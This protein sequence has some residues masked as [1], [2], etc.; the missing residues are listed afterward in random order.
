MHAAQLHV[1]QLVH[2]QLAARV[3]QADDDAVDLVRARTMARDVVDGAD[4]RARR[5]RAARMPS[6]S[7]KPTI[8][9]PS[10]WRRCF[11]SAAR[12]SAAGPVPTTSS[13]SRG[14][15]APDRP[16]EGEAP[17]GDERDD[18]RRGKQ[19]HA[20]A[21]HQRRKP[22]VEQRQDQRGRAE[23]LQ[24]AHEQLAAVG[25]DAQVVQLRVVQAHLADGG[26][27]D[28]LDGATRSR[29]HRSARPARGAAAR[30]QR[31]ARPSSSTLSNRIRT[32]LRQVT[33][34]KAVGH[35]RSALPGR[36]VRRR[37]SRR[38][39]GSCAAALG[40]VQHDA[41][42]ALPADRVGGALDQLVRRRL[43]AHDEQRRRPPSPPAGWRR[44]AGR[45]AACR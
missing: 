30:R 2:R 26:D 9:T 23:R 11:S 43:G 24:D 42:D 40:A 35:E 25:D 22:V 44:S 5:R 15:D 31:A 7:T 36:A 29:G 14:A 21:D 8:S 28:H 13:R 4:D 16:L 45:P 39:R 1:E 20:A 10:S 3:G 18:S 12:V 34:W 6:A 41:G 32:A 33:C 17:A 38:S 37:S 27:Q 19:E